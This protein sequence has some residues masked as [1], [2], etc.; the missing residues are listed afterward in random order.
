MPVRLTLKKKLTEHSVSGM[1]T[2]NG[3]RLSGTHRPK[4]PAWKECRNPRSL[5]SHVSRCDCRTLRM[6]K[7]KCCKTWCGWVGQK[8]KRKNALELSPTAYAWRLKV[9][10]QH[11]PWRVDIH[12]SAFE[13][14]KALSLQENDLIHLCYIFLHSIRT[15]LKIKFPTI[16]TNGKAQVGRAGAKNRKKITKGKEPEERRCTAGER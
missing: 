3:L 11:E 7:G 16:W 13:T 8:E 15:P 12:H 2:R 4:A 9:C 10:M 14:N 5:K 1:V 6:W